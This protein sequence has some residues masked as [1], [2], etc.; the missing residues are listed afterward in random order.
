MTQED[1]K[2]RVLGNFDATFNFTDRCKDCE[3]GLIHIYDQL[4]NTTVL[5]DLKN[6]I[7]Q[8]LDTAFQEWAEAVRMEKIDDEIQQPYLNHVKNDS[9]NCC[10][11]SLCGFSEMNMVEDENGEF[12][13]SCSVWSSSFKGNWLRWIDGSG[14]EARKY[15]NM[16][17]PNAYNQAVDE[18]NKKLQELGE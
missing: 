18:L 10:Y 12:A 2:K 17:Y 13:C 4:G 1:I 3:E 14:E 6:F 7:S 5:E 11:C 8:A 15:R 9:T 16:F